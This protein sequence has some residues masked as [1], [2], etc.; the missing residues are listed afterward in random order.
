M[1]SEWYAMGL[2]RFVL[3]VERVNEVSRVGV[4]LFFGNSLRHETYVVCD[5]QN[6]VFSR[7]FLVHFIVVCLKNPNRTLGSLIF[8]LC[9]L[10]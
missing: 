1:E 5:T 7:Q 2:V 3:K 9:F 10:D 4:D 6:G 8:K